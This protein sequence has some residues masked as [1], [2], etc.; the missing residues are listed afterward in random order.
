MGTPIPNYVTNLDRR[1]RT[2]GVVPGGRN[3]SLCDAPDPV[4]SLPARDRPARAQGDLLLELHQ[5]PAFV[6]AETVPRTPFGKLH[7][8][9]SLPG[10]RRLV[11][12]A[13]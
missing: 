5:L 3:R 7:A 6:A 1:P 9:R 8:K 13:P 10:L 11:E 2:V 12:W 4:V